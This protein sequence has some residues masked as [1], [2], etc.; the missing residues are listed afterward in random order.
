M[1][2]PPVPWLSGSCGFAEMVRYTTCPSPFGT[3]LI[4]F[5][6]NSVVSLKLGSIGFLPPG[7]C[8]AAELAAEQLQAYFAGIRKI[9]TFPIKLQGTPF[10][11][12]VWEELT[13][14]P[15][16]CTVTY[17]DIA[18]AIGNEKAVRA[19]GMAC[20]R[21]PI[22]IAIPCHR[23]VGTNRKLTGYAG[24]LSMKES[25]LTLEITNI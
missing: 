8:T 3:L 24:G 6:E 9:F 20:N 12:S 19:V 13:K 4:G 25:L 18:T 22:W 17:K 21:N 14:I 10:Q 5:E 7:S 16:G 15:Y 1:L 2:P 23:V 11:I